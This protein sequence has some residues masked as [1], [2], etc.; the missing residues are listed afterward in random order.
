[1]KHSI[2]SAFSL[3][4]AAAA[5]APAQLQSIRQGRDSYDSRDQGDEFG[6]A[7][8][9]GDFN[10]DGFGDLATGSPGEGAYSD[11]ADLDSGIVI[12]SKG[13]EHGITWNGAWRLKPGDSPSIP[14]DNEAFR[15]GSALAA[16]DFNG[17]GRD[18][19]AVGAPGQEKVFVYYGH[20]L[21][22]GGVSYVFNSGTFGI[23]ENGLSNFGHALAAGRLAGD[24]YD[25]LVIGA[26]GNTG[27]VYVL[28]GS[29]TGLTT[30]GGSVI[31]PANLPQPPSSAAFF[32][33]ALAIGNVAGA[34]ALDLIIGAPHA[35]V[36]GH[37]QAGVVCVIPGTNTVSSL[38]AAA[39]LTYDQSATTGSPGPQNR[40]GA[41]VAIG[42]F[43]NDGG[44]QDFAV[45]CPG[46]DS[47]IG[48]VYIAKGQL[49]SPVFT[50]TLAQ[51]PAEQENG[52]VFGE[53]LATGDQDADGFDDLA[54]GSPGEFMSASEGPLANGASD[55]TYTGRVQIF[56]GSA[57]QLSPA[58]QQDFWYHYVNRA[59]EA[60]TKVGAALASGRI[61][62]GSR[63]S[64]LIGAPGQNNNRGEVID[65]APWRQP[66]APQVS[67]G[68]AVNCDGEII[69]A[70]RP[71]DELKIASTTKI[72]TVL[73]A[74]E[75]TQKPANDPGFRNFTGNYAIETWLPQA[76][77]PTSTCSI[78]GFRNN[79][80]VTFEGLMRTCMM[81]SGNDSAMAI[82]DVMTGEI[83]TWQGTTQSAPLFVQMMNARAAQIGMN[84]TL[85]TNPPGVDSGDPYST[86]WD[87]YLLAR[88]AMKN[89]RFRDIAGR[90]TWP[91]NHLLPDGLLPGSLSPGTEIVTNGW[92][93]GLKGNV[94]TAIGI[95]PGSTGGAGRTAVCAAPDPNNPAKWAI[96]NVFGAVGSD[97]LGGSRSARPLQ[98]ALNGCWDAPPLAGGGL[99]IPP[100]HTH[101]IRPQTGS[102]AGV[103]IKFPDGNNFMADGS[104]GTAWTLDV[105]SVDRSAAENVDVIVDYRGLFDLATLGT[106]MGNKPLDRLVLDFS[107]IL[108]FEEITLSNTGMEPLELEITGLEPTPHALLL[109]AVQKVREAAARTTSGVHMEIRNMSRTVPGTITVELNGVRFHPSFGSIAP[110]RSGHRFFRSLEPVQESMH[111]F[112]FATGPTSP[113]PLTLVFQPDGTNFIYPHPVA[114]ERIALTD[115]AAG[116]QV[117]L[118]WTA[119]IDFYS[120]F[121]VMF[122]RD[123]SAGSWSPLATVPSGSTALRTWTGPKPA[124]SRGYFRVE[125][126]FAP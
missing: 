74:C 26:P 123:M 92:L 62:P 68:M 36:N 119:P 1:M 90:T 53:T 37:L 58:A 108:S 54:V 3:F 11:P 28:K 40:F 16:G 79:D 44:E 101:G 27:R 46:N 95:K 17:D 7:M 84:D 115:G 38:T 24:A 83:S 21:G 106:S 121:R 105:Q 82:A 33:A 19:L 88:E 49:L 94:P 9:V 78:F 56:R 64:F 85:F 80:A 70:L 45:G 76:Y 29:A 35:V 96:A 61:T 5:S 73:L 112:F 65:F 14:S 55:L 43:F 48:R 116:A 99:T 103:A 31:E 51:A 89:S 117:Q 30:T 109:P 102:P 63:R 39:A 71:W 69:W 120:N 77:P 124:G 125:G 67:S 113:E 42:N 52:D 57:A 32:G 10:G 111:A 118:D 13:T 6:A 72:M 41:S 59:P 20:A 126:A 87:M 98:L 93:Q 18:D 8:A 50:Q 100:M 114:M 34:P 23:G 104:P 81:V 25:D 22:L 91:F 60:G 86:A 47:R 110:W 107:N 4:L 122:S 75:A 97:L 12:F 2:L 15:F 66:A